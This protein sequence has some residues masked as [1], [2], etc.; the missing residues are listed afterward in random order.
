MLGRD[1]KKG[2]QETAQSPLFQMFSEGARMT[3]LRR[4]GFTSI[5]ENGAVE[6]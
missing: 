2:G 3:R 5:G 6:E 1:G 4:A